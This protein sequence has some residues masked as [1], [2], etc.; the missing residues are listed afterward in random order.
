MGL[1]ESKKAATRLQISNLATQLFL[2]KGF[3]A[4]SVADVAE[5]A[6]VSKMTVF[7]YF[8]RKE[9]LLFDRDEE[10]RVILRAAILQRAP[11]TTVIH[12]LEHMPARLLEGEHP[13]VQW[14]ERTTKFFDLIRESPA[15]VARLREIREEAEIEIA[16]VLEEAVA[17]KDDPLARILA[18]AFITAWR[19]AYEAAA[20]AR[21]SGKRQSVI[22]T[23]FLET[24]ATG[25]TVIKRGA[26]GTPY[27]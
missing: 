17:K 10:I 16:A 12:A 24:F 9:D 2:E 6:N 11:R 15:L 1:R 27:G 14:S 13:L 7:N 22:K 19:V 21:K 25:F 18:S 23:T 26:K 3:D 20:Q 8:A 4:V 5:A